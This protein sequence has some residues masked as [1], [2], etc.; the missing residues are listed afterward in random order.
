[1]LEGGIVGVVIEWCSDFLERWEIQGVCMD[2][3][4]LLSM[5]FKQYKRNTSFHLD[6]FSDPWLIPSDS[7]AA[8]PRTSKC[9]IYL[10]SLPPF[11]IFRINERSYLDSVCLVNSKPSCWFVISSLQHLWKRL[12]GKKPKRLNRTQIATNTF[13]EGTKHGKVIFQAL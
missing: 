12:T 8:T 4:D 6:Y 5:L 2:I 13:F 7:L 1:M 11:E 10:D 3:A 9:A